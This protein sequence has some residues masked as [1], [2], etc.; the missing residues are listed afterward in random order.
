MTGEN[1]RLNRDGVACRL[2]GQRICW[3]TI[4]VYRQQEVAFEFVT[5]PFQTENH[6]QFGRVDGGE[7]T[8]PSF[9][10]LDMPNR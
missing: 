3:G 9:R 2:T 10:S 1:N 8:Q 4:I 6:R 5:H 7:N